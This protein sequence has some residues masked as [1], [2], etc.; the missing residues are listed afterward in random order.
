MGRKFAK[1]R[2]MFLFYINFSIG[3]RGDIVFPADSSQKIGKPGPHRI[4]IKLSQERSMVEA[5]PGAFSVVNIILKGRFGWSRPPIGWVVQ[6]Y[7]EF[8]V[9]KKS[10]GNGI[11]FVDHKVFEVLFLTVMAKPI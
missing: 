11:R 5:N 7:E 8:V 3:S 4:A 6:L 2:M 10:F 9:G 1:N